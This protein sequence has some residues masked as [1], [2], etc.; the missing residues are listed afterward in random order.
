MTPAP[1]PAT[2]DSIG[3]SPVAGHI[4]AEIAGVN[5]AEPLTPPAVEEIRNA[6]LAHRVLFFRDQH[7]DHR[8]HIA[9]ARNF[10]EVTRADPHRDGTDPQFPEILV[11]DP[12]PDEQRYGKD[13]EQR[14]RRRRLAHYSSWHIDNSMVVNPPAG[15]IL[16]AETV[17]AYGGD[18]QWTN[19]VAAYEGLSKPLRDL[20]DGLR[21]EHRFLAGFQMLDHDE[22]VS[23]IVAMSNT[24]PVIA[25]HPI[26]RVIPETGERA[27]FVSPST[28]S[29]ILELS[30]VE[31]RTLL[32]L[33]SEQLIRDEY[34]VRLRW[35][36]G[37][38]A[39]WDNRTTA[40]LA[41]LDHDH[42]N[43]PRRLYRVTLVGERPV[44]P[45]GVPSEAVAGAALTAPPSGPWQTLPAGNF[46]HPLR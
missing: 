30:T 23:E 2:A 14:Y 27:L 10:G 11:V 44:G 6:L 29:R 38:V 9:F 40:H 33:F 45:D 43:S 16:R 46:Q 7:I 20:A 34:R 42:L 1:A 24:N 41:A 12:Q 5:M 13:F 26:V 8:E 37:T 4:G 18:T 25:V 21:A 32:D 22:E 19:L 35:A 36:P 28:T 15:S 3:I 39:F 31:S 17:P